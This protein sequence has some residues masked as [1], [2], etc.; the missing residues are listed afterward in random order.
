[1]PE[2]RKDPIIGRWIIISTERGKRPTDFIVE[3]SETRGGFCPLCPGN[4]NTT[5]PEVLSYSNTAG[6]QANRPGWDLRVV[7]NKYPALIIEGN[8][9]KEGDGLYDRMNG[10]GA[11]EVIIET[12]DHNESFANLPADRMIKVF[13]AYRDR[14][15]DL[16]QDPRFRYVMV[17]KNFGAAAGAS[18]EHSHSQLIA[19]P[20]VPRMISSEI[21]GSL[22]YF[23]YKERCIFCDIIRQ[24]INQNKRVVAE[25]DLF[26]AIV[27]YAPRSPFEMWILPKQHASSYLAMDDNHFKALTAIFSECMRRLDTCIPNVP[28]NF[29]LHGAPLRSQ[30]LEHYHWHFEIMPK[31]TMIAGFEWGS[32]FYI[33]S[34]PPEEAAQFLREAAI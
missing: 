5:P 27:P 25:N 22:S 32:G 18:L 26:L 24:E 12:P 13:L 1:M 9:N 3:K 21:E 10:I 8:L 31:L 19:L 4:E 20:I 30:P 23:K 17:F 16:A 11:H 28:Y 34:I 15:L 2:L 7:P 29:V 33:N 14:L 6:H